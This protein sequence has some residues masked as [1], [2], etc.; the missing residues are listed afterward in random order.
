MPSQLGR[1][2]D[3]RVAAEKLARIR[4]AHVAPLNRLA[5]EIAEAHSLP[6]GHVPYVDP[7][8]G[9]INARALVLLDNPS[10]KAEAG[11]GSGLLSLD[12]DDATARNCRLIYRQHGVEWG[13]VVHWSVCPFPTSNEKNGSSLASERAR[14]AMW[15]ARSV[16]L[17][18]RLEYVLLLGRAA[19]DGWRRTPIDRPDLIVSHDVPHCSRRGLS[20]QANRTRFED[21]V[22]DMSRHLAGQRS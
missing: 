12:N 14:G 5:D 9:G 15:T 10:T 1:N 3:Q 17:L 11:T 22:R 19:E 2:R 8:L 13:D 6:R 4:Q 16:D 18:P 21:A 7:D 20:T